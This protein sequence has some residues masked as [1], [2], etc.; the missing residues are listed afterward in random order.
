M[1]EFSS[2]EVEWCISSDGVKGQQMYSK[3]RAFADKKMIKLR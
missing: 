1:D 3:N 2:A